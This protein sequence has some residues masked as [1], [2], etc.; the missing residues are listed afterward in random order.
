MNQPTFRI[1]GLETTFSEASETRTSSAPRAHTARG[2]SPIL[3]IDY[4]RDGL[5]ERR[6]TVRLGDLLP[7]LLDAAHTRKAW[8]R[9][10]E[11]DLL[12]VPQDLYEVVLAYGSMKRAA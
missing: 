1:L 9:G 5:A 10:F 7:M 6:V 11:D 3:G 8:L 2:A 4:D 12:D